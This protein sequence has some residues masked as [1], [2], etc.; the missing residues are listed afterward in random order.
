MMP[1]GGQPG[2]VEAFVATLIPD[3]PLKQHADAA[4]TQARSHGAIFA[5]KDLEK[6]RLRA[7]LAWQRVPGAPYGR[8][9]ELY[10]A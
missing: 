2:A 9:I 4:T 10:L 7:W 6:A 1:Q 5:D 3:S 8:A